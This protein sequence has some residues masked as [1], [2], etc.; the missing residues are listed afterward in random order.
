MA[1]GHLTVSMEDARRNGRRLS[2]EIWYPASH[3][4]N[5][6]TRY[7]LL[8][9]IAFDSTIATENAAPSASRHPLVIWSHGRTGLRHNYTHL[10]E[11]LAARGFVVASADHPGDTLFDWLTGANVDDET[12]ERQRL[13][14]VSFLIDAL[15]GTPT[16]IADGDMSLPLRVVDPNAVFVGGHSYGG[17]TAIISA[18]GIHGI[19]GDPRVRAIAGAQAY[20]RTLPREVVDRL[21]VPALLLVG[22]G[23]RTTPP[24]TDA[25]PVWALLNTD[26]ARHHR[27][28]LEHGGHQACSDFAFYM[29]MLP[30]IPGVPQMV[31]DYLESIAADS[32][33]G[34]RE[35]WRITIERHIEAISDFFG[36]RLR[37]G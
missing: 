7:E 16:R 28:D 37:G 14:D 21:G 8:P 19:P 32:P 4:S 30:S 29:E 10:C 24:S 5:Q 15:T 1:V 27:I 34:F 13:G 18:T 9:G 22:L 35:T 11:G 20:T 36:R 2:T 12:N 23:D 33:R 25:D 3:P 6:P 26:G 31:V 17:L